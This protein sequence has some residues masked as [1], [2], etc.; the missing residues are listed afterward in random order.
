MIFLAGRTLSV[1]LPAVCCALVSQRP[2]GEAAACVGVL[3]CVSLSGG[4]TPGSH[5]L[6][7]QRKTFLFRLLLGLPG[8]ANM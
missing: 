6:C 3:C 4:S 2:L 1:S 5:L 7:S 8:D